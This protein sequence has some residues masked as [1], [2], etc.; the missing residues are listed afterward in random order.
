[1]KRIGIIAAMEEEKNAIKNIMKNIKE[2]KIYELVFIE[3]KINE[4][5]CI[6]VESGVGKVNSSR[7]TQLM[8]DKYDVEYIINIG[9]AGSATNELK[10]GDIVIGERIVQHDFDI[11]AFGHKKGYISNVG[12]CI[13][14]DKLLIN[15]F[16]EV[17]KKIQD[18]NINIKIGTI[19]T[20]DIFC[21]DIKMR[22]KIN[23]KFSADAIEMEA[24]SI[25]QVCYLDKIPFII[26]R[27]ISDN[28]DGKNEITFE[29]Y[30]ELASKRCAEILKEFI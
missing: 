4:K 15:R 21:T 24:A 16:I 9:S 23:K 26:L 20:G 14:S 25:A 28:P 7:T 12:E 29:N 8:I 30:L 10:I 18:E 6:L 27:S 3:G 13:K 19:A 17:I 11:T 2:I 22:D 1:M 5:E